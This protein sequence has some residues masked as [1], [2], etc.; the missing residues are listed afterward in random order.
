MSREQCCSV[1][2]CVCVCVCV[3][4]KLHTTAQSGPVILVILRHSRL[5][6][7]LNAC[8]PSEHPPV[9]GEN[10]KTFRWDHGLVLL[11]GGS[12]TLIMKTFD[13]TRQRGRNLST[14]SSHLSPERLVAL[15]CFF[16]F[17]FLAAE[18]GN[19]NR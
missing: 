3:F 10:V 16:C 8:R 12:M 14:V 6:K 13:Q 7:N 17:C 19:G 15:G 9:G 4:I 11:K 5:N 18:I 1:C 2:V